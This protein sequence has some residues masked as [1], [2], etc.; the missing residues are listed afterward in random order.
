MDVEDLEME[1]QGGRVVR[2][3]PPSLWNSYPRDIITP[4]R[5]ARLMHAAAHLVPRACAPTCLPSLTLLLLST[6]TCC[7]LLPHT[8]WTPTAYLPYYFA[9]L[10]APFCFCLN[11]HLG[12]SFSLGREGYAAMCVSQPGVTGQSY[13]AHVSIRACFSLMAWLWLERGPSVRQWQWWAMKDR[14]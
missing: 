6:T 2:Y 12:I 7:C 8:F 11:K 9:R 10:P 13:I 4:A 5:R 3:F 14:N 1:R